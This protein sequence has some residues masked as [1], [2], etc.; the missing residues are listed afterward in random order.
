MAVAFPGTRIDKPRPIVRFSASSPPR[1]KLTQCDSFLYLVLG[2]ETLYDRPDRFMDE[3][4]VVITDIPQA[5]PWYT[6]YTTFKRWGSTPWSRIPLEVVLP[7]TMFSKL[8]VLLPTIAYAVTFT[9]TNVLLT[10]R[11][12]KPC[13]SNSDPRAQA[14]LRNPGGDPVAHRQEVQPERTANRTSVY[15]GSHREYP[16]RTHRWVRQRQVHGLAHTEGE[17][18]A[19]AR[20]ALI[21]N[22]RT[23]HSPANASCRCDCPWPFRALSLL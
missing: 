7:L 23:H 13:F 4:V 6:P 9:F 11:G 1:A 3:K 2:P 14:D 12:F 16:R 21:Q 18:T 10:V 17:W 22:G 5:T 19:R 20:G 8:P 15:G